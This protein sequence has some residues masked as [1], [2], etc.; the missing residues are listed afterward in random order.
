[1]KIIYFSFDY[2]SH[3]QRFLTALACQ[4]ARSLLRAPAARSSAN[5]DRPIPA[6]IRQVQWAGGR[7]PFAWRDLPRLAWDFRRLVREI[8]PDLIHAGPI[9]TCAFI[10]ALSGFHPLLSMSWGFDLMK[11]IERG[12]WWRFAT[13]YT[14]KRSDYFTSGRLCD[15]RP[16]RSLWHAPRADG[17]FP[18]GR[19]S[20]GFQP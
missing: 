17:G 18:L 8:K 12:R 15:P 1:M 7:K 11:D 13:R 14:L 19:G 20:G 9:Q 2:T 5:E 3:D 6:E 10:A 4:R 16:G